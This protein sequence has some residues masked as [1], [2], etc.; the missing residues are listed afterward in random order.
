MTFYV[1][2]SGSDHHR[3]K[4]LQT[5]IAY[6]LGAVVQLRVE[7][8]A[9]NLDEIMSIQ[10]GGCCAVVACSAGDGGRKACAAARRSGSAGLAAV[11]DSDS[12]AKKQIRS[13]EALARPTG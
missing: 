7:N 3:L 11:C 12:A 10:L 6:E 8:D 1:D 2:A 9:T 13:G 5:S 4:N